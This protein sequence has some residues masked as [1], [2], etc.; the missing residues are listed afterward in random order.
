MTQH[1][2]STET[3]GVDAAE[4]AEQYD[5]TLEAVITEAYR[6]LEWMLL[7]GVAADGY[8]IVVAD[9]KA[10]LDRRLVQEIKTRFEHQQMVQSEKE[11][12]NA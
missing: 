5:T 3:R 12:S 11:R 2:L 7:S 1:S 8:T 9:D 6:V 4:L 10:Y